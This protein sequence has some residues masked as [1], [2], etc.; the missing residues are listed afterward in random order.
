M[1]L[2]EMM[3]PT[4]VECRI[5]SQ[6]EIHDARQ[7]VSLTKRFNYLELGYN[8]VFQPMPAVLTAESVSL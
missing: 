6:D 1:A 4:V 5:H 3:P 2:L 8:R 7:L